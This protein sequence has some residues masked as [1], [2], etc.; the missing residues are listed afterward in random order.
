MSKNREE[1]KSKKREIKNI[2]KSRR[3]N[4]QKIEK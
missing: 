1:K 2:G 3:K 4:C